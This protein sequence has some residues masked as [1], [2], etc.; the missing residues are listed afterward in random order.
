ME[1]GGVERRMGGEG[2]GGDLGDIDVDVCD[3]CREEAAEDGN[4]PAGNA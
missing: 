3:D 2:R 4:A 1:G